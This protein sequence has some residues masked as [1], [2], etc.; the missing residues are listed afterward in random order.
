MN[1]STR[2]RA[3]VALLGI[4]IALSGC[5]YSREGPPSPYISPWPPQALPLEKKSVVV[6]V[7]RTVA[8]ES[9]RHELKEHPRLQEL[10]MDVY[11]DSRLFSRVGESRP[12]KPQ[13][14]ADL[15]VHIDATP[16][17]NMALS[18]ASGWLSGMSLFIIPG[19]TTA[20]VVSVTT[21]TDGNHRVLG[22]IRRREGVSV[23][24][25]LLLAF[26][27]PFR[28]TPDEFREKIYTDFF[29]STINEAHATGAL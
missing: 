1:L 26:A 5:V 12:G 8:N 25:Q 24:F 10:A 23:W 6:S 4:L 29:K 28:D 22:V 14:P 27:M 20:D 11:K 13:E 21:I 17:E 18:M 2:R 19:Y 15:Y 9:S 3:L 16:E 7:T